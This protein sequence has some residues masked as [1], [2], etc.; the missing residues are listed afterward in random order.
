[1]AKLKITKNYRPSYT[2][3]EIFEGEYD[4]LVADGF[5]GNIVVK[6]CEG[7]G[8]FTKKCLGDVFRRNILSKIAYLLAKS[9]VDKLRHDTDHSIYG[10]APFLCIG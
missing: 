10:G 6:M 5:T 3:R 7:T 9:S 2:L 1:M 4:V 8:K